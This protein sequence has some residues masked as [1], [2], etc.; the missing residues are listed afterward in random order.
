LHGKSRLKK[1]VRGNFAS[2]LPDVEAAT[3]QA[4][5]LVPHVCNAEKL[6]HFTAVKMS[7]SGLVLFSLFCEFLNV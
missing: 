7:Q 4:F 1:K 2:V 6:I 5:G 3:H